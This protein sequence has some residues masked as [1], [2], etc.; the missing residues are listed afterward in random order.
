MKNIFSLDS[1]ASNIR[2]VVFNSE[3]ETL[4]SSRITTGVNMSI[5]PEESA[6]KII[7]SISGLL[8]NI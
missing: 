6:K 7:S 4:G 8:E 1:G 5:D 2:M 3:G